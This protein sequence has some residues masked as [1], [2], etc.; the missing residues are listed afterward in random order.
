MVDFEHITAR[1][2][3]RDI[4]NDAGLQPTG[5]RMTCPIHGGK[6]KTSF[7]F[8]DTGFT[9]FSCGATGGLL[10]LVEY[11]HRCTKADAM[12]HLCRLTGMPYEEPGKGGR[13]ARPTAPRMPTRHDPL[14][15][16]EEYCQACER[17]KWLE[18]HDECLTAWIQIIL[19]KRN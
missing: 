7:S 11:L 14:L 19:K 16:N 10:A 18:L 1:V 8:T 4:L 2:T 17:L 6:N 13:S 3:I 12:R 5:N 9:C 15:D